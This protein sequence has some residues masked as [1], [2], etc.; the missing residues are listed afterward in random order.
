MTL[1]IPH[2]RNKRSSH[3]HPGKILRDHFSFP[4]VNGGEAGDGCSTKNL[5]WLIA[6]FSCWVRSCV[7]PKPCVFLIHS[8]PSAFLF[9]FYSPS[10]ACSGTS[11][12]GSH[13]RFHS[14]REPTLALFWALLFP[15]APALLPSVTFI[16]NVC[17][18][19]V[20]QKYKVCTYSNTGS[21]SGNSEDR[22]CYSYLYI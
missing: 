1:L 5:W 13:T 11:Y 4:Q 7:T 14:Q 12:A 17:F 22:D 21:V 16:A 20:F 19:P 8:A 9:R 6:W 3:Q 2:Q 10:P 18:A 15:A